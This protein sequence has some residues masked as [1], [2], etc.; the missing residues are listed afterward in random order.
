MFREITRG[1]YD[2][3]FPLAILIFRRESRDE[4]YGGR[5]VKH[6]LKKNKKPIRKE[7]A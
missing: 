2:F 5:S 7:H 3:F 1:F 4:I 6:N